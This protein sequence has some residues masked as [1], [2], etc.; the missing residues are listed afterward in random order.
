LI[1]LSN[2]ELNG[3]TVQLLHCLRNVNRER[4]TF[5][6]CG[7][8]RGPLLDRY[9]SLG[10][11]V[12]LPRRRM[13]FDPLLLL[14]LTRLIRRNRFDV[15][16]TPKHTGALWGRAAAFLAGHRAVVTH[17]RGSPLEL[18]HP[19]VLAIDRFQSRRSSL[20]LV[21]SEDTKR[22]V[23]RHLGVPWDRIRVLYNAVSHPDPPAT[24][25]ARGTIRERPVIGFT[26]RLVPFKGADLFLRALPEIFRAHP[27]VRARIVGEGPLEADLRDLAECLG[28]ADQVE[29]L[30]WF[31]NAT[32]AL[33]TFD[34]LVMPSAY[35]PF[36]NVLLEAALVETP[37]VASRVGGLIE[38]AERVRHA[39]LI[40]PSLSLTASG[41]DWSAF[42]AREASLR[43]FPVLD[44][45]NIARA[46][47]RLL[48]DPELYATLSR[49]ARRRA[50]EAFPMERHVREFEAALEE[51][52]RA[53]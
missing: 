35:E 53:G 51:V 13:R 18:V 1:V 29:F 9:R 6:I 3:C 31:E 38:I 12:V 4:V 50:L 42:A 7:L 20:V 34:L 47:I 46:V 52:A 8:A 14:E 44:P 37:A 22:R 16:Y 32:D 25:R 28:V 48:D 33:G 10:F 17:E 49:G 40:E 11:P 41:R 2:F 30:P 27:E 19:F 26:G 43:R 15:V 24:G 39:V 23:M 45:A 5:T 36:G 21:N